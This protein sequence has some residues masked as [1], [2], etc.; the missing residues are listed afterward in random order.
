MAIKRQAE[1]ANNLITSCFTAVKVPVRQLIGWLS[2][3]S[4]YNTNSFK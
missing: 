3:N 1:K 2:F 4:A